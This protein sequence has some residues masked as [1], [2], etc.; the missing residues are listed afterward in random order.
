MELMLTQ[1]YL[2]RALEN[3]PL[4]LHELIV[5]LNQSENQYP[6]EIAELF[7][8]ILRDYKVIIEEELNDLSIPKIF[9]TAELLIKHIY[10]V[11]KELEHRKIRFKKVIDFRQDFRTIAAYRLINKTVEALNESL[12]KA[13]KEKK[14]YLFKEDNKLIELK[15]ITIL[16]F[17]DISKR[18][19]WG[20][21]IFLIGIILSLA[22]YCKL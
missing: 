19:T 21:W 15:K 7:Q 4:E 8:N 12:R 2:N 22:T 5:E 11:K 20:S 14:G 3:I 1:E 9:P 13:D 16:D 10:K 6:N 18:L 17:V